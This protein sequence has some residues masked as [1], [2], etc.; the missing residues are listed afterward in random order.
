MLGG[1]GDWSGMPRIE[2]VNEDGG[3]SYPV[4]TGDYDS[5]F[6]WESRP[7]AAGTPLTTPVPLFKK[8]DDSVVDEEIARL[9]S[10]PSTS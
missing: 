5:T 8:L 1:S 10:E 2:Q 6:R 9:G 4:I 7:V 3:P